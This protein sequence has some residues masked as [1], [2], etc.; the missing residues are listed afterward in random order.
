MN[1]RDTNQ[2]FPLALSHSR[3]L[4]TVPLHRYLIFFAT[5]ER[6]RVTGNAQRNHGHEIHVT[7][8]KI[9]GSTRG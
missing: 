3:L 8:A 9:R 5:W 6:S 1:I 4:Q 7:S 2:I